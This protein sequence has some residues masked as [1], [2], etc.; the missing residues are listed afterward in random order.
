ME[1]Q[2]KQLISEAQKNNDSIVRDVLRTVLGQ[3]QTESATKSISEEQKLNIVRKMIKS[4]DI[5]LT[6]MKETPE[7]NWSQDWKDNAAQLEYEN[8][9]LTS[10]LPQTWT[11]DQITAA[12]EP[13]TEAIRAAKSDGMGLGIG[14]KALKS[15]GAA[16]NAEEVKTVVANIRS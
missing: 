8:K 2:L 14:M 1:T 11:V 6:A 10:L 12:L 3:I 9:A 15:M 4:N 5:T 13:H 16:V 7:E